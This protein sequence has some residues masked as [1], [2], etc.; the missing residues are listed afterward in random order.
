MNFEVNHDFLLNVPVETDDIINA[1]QKQLEKY[2]D[3]PAIIFAYL[4]DLFNLG[5]NADLMY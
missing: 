2:K 3:N 1:Y 5:R 4:V